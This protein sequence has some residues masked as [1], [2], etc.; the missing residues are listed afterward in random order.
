MNQTVGLNQ[1]T[2]VKE[3]GVYQAPRA[4]RYNL[5]ELIPVFDQFTGEKIGTLIDFSDTGL[6]FISR[7]QFKLG[8]TLQVRLK[9]NKTDGTETNVEFLD[10]K[11]TLRQIRE[12][13]LGNMYHIGA[14]YQAVNTKTK[15]R[16]TRFLSELKQNALK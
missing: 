3:T 6:G 9:I 16:I 11:I 7:K 2:D 14:E 1:V 8:D 4:I 15:F 12:K 5:E 13:R 10:L